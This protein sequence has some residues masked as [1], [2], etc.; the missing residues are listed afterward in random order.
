SSRRCCA[1]RNIWALVDRRLLRATMCQMRANTIP[2]FATFKIFATCRRRPRPLTYRTVD[3]T[4]CGWHG[5][6]MTEVV[7][8]TDQLSLRQARERV[9]SSVKPRPTMADT[10][11]ERHG[12]P[13]SD[14]QGD[15]DR[16][17]L[18]RAPGGGN[19]PPLCRVRRGDV[20]RR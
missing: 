12:R 17:R 15:G 13:A 19:H 4:A 18:L 10:T 9:C 16:R 14:A 6:V 11:A 20:P 2:P 7:I 1:R 5:T 3:E 8:E